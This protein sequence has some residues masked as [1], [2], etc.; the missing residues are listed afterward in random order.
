MSILSIVYCFRTTWPTGLGNNI[1]I[2]IPG[3]KACRNGSVLY[4][5]AKNSYRVDDLL[6]MLDASQSGSN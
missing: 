4:S 3:K 5:F 6:N 2:K 1:N